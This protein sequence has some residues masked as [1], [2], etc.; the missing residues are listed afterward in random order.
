MPLSF[1]RITGFRRYAIIQQDLKRCRLRT[2]PY[3][4]SV[5]FYFLGVIHL[6]LFC[7]L[8]NVSENNT[9][10]KRYDDSCGDSKTCVVN[11]TLNSD[12]NPPFGLYYRLTN[13]KQMHRRI[14]S[15]YSEEML[16]GHVASKES[17]EKCYPFIYLNNSRNISN[18]FVP[19]G[20][21]ASLVFNDTFNIIN[22]SYMRDND[23]ALNTD[24]DLL[25]SEPNS[26]YNQSQLWLSDTGLFISGQVDRHFI[27]WMRKSAF[28]PFRKLYAVSNVKMPA[29]NY[30]I[31]IRNNYNTSLFNG[32]KYF[33]LTENHSLSPNIKGATNVIVYIICLLFCISATMGLMGYRRSRPDS[34]FHPDNLKLMFIST[35]L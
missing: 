15:S 21:L 5:F 8:T 22:F 19:C 10:I 29:G 34:K 20:L 12:L 13:F 35:K 26:L 30:S 4:A 32:E 24:V 25:F 31:A 17:I 11:F 16:A 7:L 18:L 14:Y 33:V 23:I 2:V 9:V 28:S 6:F 3:Y 27:V 1:S